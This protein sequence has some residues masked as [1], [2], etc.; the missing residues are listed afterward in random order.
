MGGSELTPSCSNITEL[1]VF[2]LP[3]D[4]VEEQGVER[5]EPFVLLS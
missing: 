4:L 2:D 5:L 3:F 1:S